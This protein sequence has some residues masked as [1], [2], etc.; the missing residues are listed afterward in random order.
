MEEMDLGKQQNCLNG[1]MQLKS[2]SRTDELSEEEVMK[3]IG[4]LTAQYGNYALQLLANEI[5]D[6]DD[7]PF[8]RAVIGSL[9]KQLDEKKKPPTK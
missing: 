7:S 8:S 4:T 9:K 2:K 3:R 1:C 6:G 5:E